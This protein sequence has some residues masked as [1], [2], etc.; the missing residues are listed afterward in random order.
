MEG[1]VG[2]LER[3]RGVSDAINSVVERTE[4]QQKSLEVQV[5]H[6]LLAPDAFLR[7]IH[8]WHVAPTQCCLATI[9]AD[10]C[11]HVFLDSTFMHLSE[12]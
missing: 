5:C 6:C 7:A 12:R 1:L 4:L 9:A 8:L 10:N 11:K 2:E 3:L